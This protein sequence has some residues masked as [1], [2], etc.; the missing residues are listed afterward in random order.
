MAPARQAWPL[1]MAAV[2]SVLPGMPP[3][4]AQPP[5]STASE[6]L[7][8]PAPAPPDGTG[9]ISQLPEA[10]AAVRLRH[11]PLIDCGRDLPCRVRLRGVLG[12]NGGIAVEGTAFTW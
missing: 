6:H 2:L 9:G 12:R 5:P 3:A 1:L 10:V 8:L 4:A 11:E 7:V